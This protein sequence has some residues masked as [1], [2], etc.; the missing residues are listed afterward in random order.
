MVTTNQQFTTGTFDFAIPNGEYV[1]VE[2]RPQ[3]Y[4]EL[5]AYTPASWSCKAGVSNRSFDLV[6]LEGSNVWKGIRV[7]VAANEAVSCTLTVNR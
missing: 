7:Q 3:N 1:T 5:T 2:I 6:D 4:S